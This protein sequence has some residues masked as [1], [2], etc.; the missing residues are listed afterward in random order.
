MCSFGKSSCPDSVAVSVELFLW[1]ACFDKECR[2]LSVKRLSCHI[3]S[4]AGDEQRTWM[5][6]PCCQVRQDTCTRA[7][8]TIS[9]SQPQGK[10]C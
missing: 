5:R 8:G 4:L 6:S 9:L 1:E 10:P 2:Q 7:Y 3:S